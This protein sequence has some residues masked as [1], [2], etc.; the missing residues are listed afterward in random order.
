MDYKKYHTD[1]D[2]SRYSDK[3][4]ETKAKAFISMIPEDVDTI[5][6]VGCGNGLITNQLY[7]RYDVTGLDISEPALRYVKTKKVCASASA[8]PFADREFD[9]VLSSQLLEHLEEKDFFGSLSE[10]NRVAG[11]YILI[12]VPYREHV[13]RDFIQC[14]K[15]GHVYNINHHFRSLDAN[16]FME[17]LPDFKLV[18]HTTGGVKVKPSFRWLTRMKHRFIPSQSW[19]PPYWTKKRSRYNTCP[20]CGNHFSIPFKPHPLTILYDGITWLFSPAQPYWL[21]VF[22]ERK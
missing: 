20:K 3:N 5:L 10:I 11:K 9:L 22:F 8:I 14:T 19:M 6:D 18:Y 13:E 7:G 12:S 15:C 21:F 1:F 4:I 2:W 17:N 16:V